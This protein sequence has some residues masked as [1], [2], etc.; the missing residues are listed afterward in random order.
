MAGREGEGRTENVLQG[1]A[2][3]TEPRPWRVCGCVQG[4]TTHINVPRHHCIIRTTDFAWTLCEIT[5]GFSIK[6]RHYPH[7][8]IV[9]HLG[10]QHTCKKINDNIYKVADAK[11]QISNSHQSCQEGAVRRL[12]QSLRV[13]GGAG[14]ES[15]GCLQSPG[16][17]NSQTAGL[18]RV[19]AC[20]TCWNSL[21]QNTDP[22]HLARCSPLTPDATTTVQIYAAGGNQVSSPSPSV[23]E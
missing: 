7:L 17:D 5:G 18:Q 2:G 13:P 21:T 19:N 1:E 9:S 8:P 15:S 3:R 12:R 20:V 4:Q 23:V 11:G 22:H 6:K 14:A 10:K 16:E